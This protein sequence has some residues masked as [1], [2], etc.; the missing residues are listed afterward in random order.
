MLRYPS[1][2]K[3]A[4]L[5]AFL[6]GA[7]L[8]LNALLVLGVYLDLIRYS[9]GTRAGSLL[10][11]LCTDCQPGNFQYCTEHLAFM[12]TSYGETLASWLETIWTLGSQCTLM[13]VPHGQSVFPVRPPLCSAGSIHLSA[14]VVLVPLLSHSTLAFPTFHTS[15]LENTTRKS[16]GIRLARFSK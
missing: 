15:I 6:V 3:Q 11:V 16:L 9:P 2:T 4:S 13:A 14:Q 7:S 1:Y 10:T 8:G 5:L 12:S